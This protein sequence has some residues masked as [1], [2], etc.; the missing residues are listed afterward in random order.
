MRMYKEIN[1]VIKNYVMLKYN[2][3]RPYQKD[4]EEF[5]LY[6]S[7]LMDILK[8]NKLISKYSIDDWE[9][10]GFTRFELIYLIDGIDT[11]FA[12]NFTI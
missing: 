1:R 10:E 7:N 6:L 5:K 2:D 3:D 4:I 12:M 11:G 9:M 8:Q